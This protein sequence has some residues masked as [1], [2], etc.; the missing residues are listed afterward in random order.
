MTGSPFSSGRVK[1]GAFSLTSMT[2]Y[3]YRKTMRAVTLA[4]AIVV[5]SF[6]LLAQFRV[7]QPER[8][9]PRAVGVL[10]TFKNGSR[11]L[12]PVTFFYERR[13]YDANFYHATPVPFTLYSET[14]YEVQQ[15]GKPLGTFTVQ[16]ATE[17]SAEWFGNGRFKA[18]PDRDD[19]GE[20]ARAA[21]GGG[22]RPVAASV[23]PSRR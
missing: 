13:Y 19:A 4:T 18:A 9:N 15:L 23:A 8:K 10:E 7:P 1:S 20:E 11:R 6:P 3:L 2:K 14:V 17:H 21:C 5:L 12:V 22:G 16:S